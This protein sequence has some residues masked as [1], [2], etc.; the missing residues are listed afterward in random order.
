MKKN[1][2]TRKGGYWGGWCAGQRNGMWAEL[3]AGRNGAHVDQ[4]VPRNTD[5]DTQD[6]L[7]HP[8][9]EGRAHRTVWQVDRLV[10]LQVLQLW[11]PLGRVLEEGALP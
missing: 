6:T 7:P 11:P 2:R 8:N 1:E 5:T 9:A 4:G 10:Y 3:G